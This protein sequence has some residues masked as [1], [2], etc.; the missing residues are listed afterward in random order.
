MNYT[1]AANVTHTSFGQYYD[2]SELV[3]AGQINH[4]DLETFTAEIKA[5]TKG[6]DL[7]FREVFT[8]SEK[9]ASKN[10]DLYIFETYIQRLWAYLTVQQLLERQ[11][12]LPEEQQMAVREQVLAL[13]L[14]HNF[15]T[16]LTSMV[17]TKPEGERAQVA[18]KP[19]EGKRPAPAS[20]G[21]AAVAKTQHRRIIQGARMYDVDDSYLYSSPRGGP[22]VQTRNN[23]MNTHRSQE[24]TVGHRPVPKSVLL[25]VLLPAQG[26]NTSICFNV[27][28]DKDMIPKEPVFKLLHDPATGVSINGE[29]VQRGSFLKLE[30]HKDE[31]HIKANTTGIMVTQKGKETFMLWTD[32]ATS[33]HC[34]GITIALQNEVLGIAVGNI[35]VNI[36]LHKTSNDSFLWL[37]IRLQTPIPGAKGLLGQSP[38]SYVIKETSPLVKL[39]ILGKEVL[40]T[41]VS[42][43]DYSTHVK[44]TVDCW[45]V[46]FSSVVPESVLEILGL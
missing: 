34:D 46:P 2:G 10:L 20:P 32:N 8:E 33:H 14:K 40:A 30:V 13:S 7:I 25:K 45:L 26:Q 17:V 44:T 18:N 3:V 39:E 9:D 22:H 27:D 15:V 35:S 43:V 12:L 36:L 6:N 19:K 21:S 23:V 1:G 42:A 24:I 37:D 29:A 11:V 38:V 31:C 41:R 4:N 5:K 16:P 28:V